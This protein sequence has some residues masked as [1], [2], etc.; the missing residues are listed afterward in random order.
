MKWEELR[1]DIENSE[2]VLAFI[3]ETEESLCTQVKLPKQ[4]LLQ[5]IDNC[6]YHKYL[7]VDISNLDDEPDDE[8]DYEI[9]A[10]E[11]GC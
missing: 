11:N 1:A 3:G 5:A 8:P 2:Y 4:L 6:I 9:G 7:P 10:D